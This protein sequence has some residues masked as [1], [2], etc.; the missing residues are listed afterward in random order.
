MTGRAVRIAVVAVLWWLAIASMTAAGAAGPGAASGPSAVGLSG[1]RPRLVVVISIDQF[2]G[3]YLTRFA[4][5][6]LPAVGVAGAPGREVPG[7]VGGFRYL[8]ERGAYFTDA[9]HDHYPLFTGPGHAV[10]LTGA[11]PY[12]SGIVGN[13]WFDRELGRRRYCVGDDASPLVGTA[14]TSGAPAR[15]GISPATL[16]VS[17]VG[18]ELKMATGGRA[19]VWGLALKDRAAVLLAGRLA[20]GALW[21]DDMS[22]AWISSRFYRPDGTLPPWVAAWNAER[23][24]DAWLGKEWTLSVPA[25]AL[26]RV[27]TPGSRWAAAPPALGAGFPHRVGG[28]GARPGKDSYSAF[29]A[30][31]FGNDFTFEMARELIR[32]EGLGQGEVPDL[33]AINL[34]SNDYIGHAFGPDSPEVLDAAVRTDHQLADFFA[35]LDQAVPGGLGGVLVAV[36]ADHGVAPVPGAAREAK[37]PAGAYDEE[38]VAAAA[39]RALQAAYGPGKWVTALVESNLYFDLAALDAHH[40]QHAAAEDVAAAAVAR[41]PG[42]Y[43][44]YGRT[45]ILEGGLPRTDVGDRIERSFHPKLSGDLVLVTA[46]FWVPGTL[47]GITHGSP[48]AYDTRVPLLL[49]GPGIRPGRYAARVSTLDLAPTLADLLGVLPPAG[50]EGRVLAEAER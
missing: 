25:A 34:S 28:G 41:L 37:L 32:R 10:L 29:A 31:P 27:W 36:S 22:G 15:P 23:H 12:K 39:E 50:S 19:K 3:D 49:A 18:D 26:A 20:D 6:W 4:D 35:F 13:S 33:L 17:T 24:A 9:R 42:I 43:A 44:A 8:M 21:F 14:G 30:T 11:P 40:V 2:R 16:Q 1:P 47:S 7:K 45:R 38:A 46:P 48:Y 5:L